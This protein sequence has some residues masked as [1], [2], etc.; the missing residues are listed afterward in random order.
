M[1][2]HRYPSS[3]TRL[4]P[5]C[6]Q[7]TV[8]YGSSCNPPLPQLPLG[9]CSATQSAAHDSRALVSGTFSAAYRSAI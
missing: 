7:G 9:S 2:S 4:A 5:Y 8:P 6:T 3:L 1:N